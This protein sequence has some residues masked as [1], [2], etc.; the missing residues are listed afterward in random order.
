MRKFQKLFKFHNKPI[1]CF[2]Y[3]QNMQ[4]LK[5]TFLTFEHAITVLLPQFRY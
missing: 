1:I 3:Y 2:D 4:F 5:T